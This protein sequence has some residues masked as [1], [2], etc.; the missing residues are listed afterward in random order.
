MGGSLFDRITRTLVDTAPRR[1]A[2]RALAGSGL[3]AVAGGLGLGEVAAKKRRKKR[4]RR[5][6]QH[7]GGKRKCCN[8]SGLVRCEEFPVLDCPDISGFYCCGQVGAKCD[9]D[10]GEPRG[11]D[12]ETFGNC[13]CCSPLFCGRQTNG[14]FRC[15]IEDT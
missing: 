4:C 15:Q 11:P 6:G 7:C 13:S 10:F 8:G 2:V 1:E 12:P 3:A 14:E 9:P 5:I